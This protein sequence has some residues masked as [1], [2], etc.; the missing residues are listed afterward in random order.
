M[1]IKEMF[2]KVEA[3]NEIA[4]IVGAH[5]MMIVFEDDI[6]T[7]EKFATYKEFVKFAKETYIAPVYN[8]ILL[9]EYEFENKKNISTEEHGLC[10]EL[11]LCAK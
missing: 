2:K 4:K 8:A 3:Y 1:T 6:Y 5:E 9:G 10:V 11:Y 7:H